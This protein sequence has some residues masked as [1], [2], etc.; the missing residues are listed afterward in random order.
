MVLSY[1]LFSNR[2]M[3]SLTLSYIYWIG[4]ICQHKAT[5]QMN[6][7]TKSYSLVS[8]EQVKLQFSG[9]TLKTNNL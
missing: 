9:D 4:V 8:V 6:S 5:T 7:D 3:T 1:A 2:K